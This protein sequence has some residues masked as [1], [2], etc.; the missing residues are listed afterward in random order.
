MYSQNEEEKYI[1]EFFGEF[2]GTLLSIGENDGKTLS[3]S[4]RLIELGW[5][6]VLVEPSPMA[7]VNMKFLH[8][9]RKEQITFVNKA[10]AD[11]DGEFLFFESG[12]HLHQGDTS[13]LSTLDP[14][15]MK[16]WEASG[17][18]FEKTMVDCLSYDSL[19]KLVKPENKF[20]FITIDAEGVDL[21]ILKQIDLWNTAMLCIEWNSDDLLK[22][23]ILKHTYKYDMKKIIYQ[24]AENLII[25]RSGI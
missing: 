10:I 12:S 7:F 23:E 11:K 4:L 20:D 13:L 2:K 18:T 22:V 9:D 15:E 8:K 25:V 16:R 17:E 14:E 21:I 24:S 3:N 19:L 5:R 6:A 1:T